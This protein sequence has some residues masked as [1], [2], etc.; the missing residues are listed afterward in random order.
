MIFDSLGQEEGDTLQR[1]K[2]YLQ[3]CLVAPFLMQP[4]VLEITISPF[5]VAQAWAPQCQLMQLNTTSI[6]CKVTSYYI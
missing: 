3:L 4:K 2:Y 6:S 1:C 5:M